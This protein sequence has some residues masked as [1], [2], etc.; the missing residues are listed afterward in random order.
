MKGIIYNQGVGGAGSNEIVEGKLIKAST[1]SSWTGSYPSNMSNDVDG[2]YYNIGGSGTIYKY[3]FGGNDFTSIRIKKNGNNYSLSNYQYARIHNIDNDYVL[4]IDY[5]NSTNTSRLINVMLADVRDGAN[6][7]IISEYSYNPIGSSDGYTYNY[8]TSYDNTT[9]DL[10]IWFCAN[11]EWRDFISAVRCEDNTVSLLQSPIQFTHDS[12]YYRVCDEIKSIGNHRF[13]IS[14]QCY[15][16]S[17]TSYRRTEVIGVNT[18]NSPIS[19]SRYI[20]DN[21]E[22]N[23][24]NHFFC[25]QDTN[26]MALCKYYITSSGHYVKIYRTNFNNDTITITRLL[27]PTQIFMQSM[28]QEGWGIRSGIVFEKETGKLVVMANDN[29]S[30]NK[31]HYI[32]FT[33]GDNTYIEDACITDTYSYMNSNLTCVCYNGVYACV[34]SSYDILEAYYNNGAVKFKYGIYGD[35]YAMNKNCN[36]KGFYTSS[37]NIYL[38]DKETHTFNSTG[39][40]ISGSGMATLIN[41]TTVSTQAFN[42]KLETNKNGVVKIDGTTKTGYLESYYLNS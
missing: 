24:Y 10:L 26:S 39:L 42:T 20:D 41:N 28:S 12:G 22:G 38:I 15:L 34:K 33:I 6:A 40:S 36:R 13:V 5:N 18:S 19:Y 27:A 16:R 30:Q 3:V 1:N 35:S 21:Y 31:Y 37:A 29:N 25:C 2:T 23:I 14:N 11:Q 7:N 9:G 17:N 4:I 8:T 32:Q